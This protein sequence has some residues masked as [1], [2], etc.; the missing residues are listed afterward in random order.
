MIAEAL[1][2]LRPTA[3]WILK[4]DEI[5][6]LDTKQTRPT[7]EEIK[8]EIVKLKAKA[9]I[10]EKTRL[11]SKQASLAKLAKLGLTPEDIKNILG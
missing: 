6:W 4:D 10:D 2:S 8:A 9:V 1:F 5:E 7:D 3:Q 11:D